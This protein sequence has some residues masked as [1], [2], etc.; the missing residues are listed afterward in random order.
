MRVA[1]WSPSAGRG[2]LAALEPHLE[3]DAEIGLVSQEPPS[4]P[5]A[6]LHLY[7][8]G[9]DPAYGYVYRA[10]LRQPGL[11]VLEDWGLHRLVHAE[12]AGRGDEAGY[13]REARR[14]HGELGAF[15]AR[16]VTRGLG[17]ALPASLLVMNDRVLDAGLAFVATSE[18]VRSQLA[19][20]LPHRPVVHLPLAFQAP[21]APARDGGR[22]DLG[23]SHERVLVVALPPPGAENPPAG[24]VRA[25]DEVREAEPEVTIRWARESDPDLAS[26]VAAADVVVALEHP[27][28]AGL[29]AAVPLA[30]AAGRCVLVSAGSG[31]AREI[32]DGVVAH[33][34]PGPT[35]IVETV[36]LVRRLL[37]D[38]SLRSR[39]GRLALAHAAERRDPEGSAR[40]LL[41]LLGDVEATREGA[42]VRLAARR[43][44]Q[45]GLVSGA[46]DEIGVA[47]RELGMADLPPGLASLADELLGE[48]VP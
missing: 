45:N 30:V 47:A 44:A 25:L 42:E 10:L 21:P 39:M 1:L 37:S 35:E 22:S 17:G 33:V 38:A 3:S 14:S 4:D 2:W 36:A 26:R 15:V 41:D 13:R 20:R 29:G 6:D 23:V 34:S 48:R 28:R 40:A 5:A 32:P 9:D 18:A 11:V 43:S 19:A 24:V 7:H 27:P 8:V 16:Q 46:L 31:A 12:T